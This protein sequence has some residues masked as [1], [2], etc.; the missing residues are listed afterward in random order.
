[1]GIG[2]WGAIS[3]RD[4]LDPA[5]SGPE[6]RGERRLADGGEST[7][8]VGAVEYTAD[9]RSN[10]A[11][12]AALEPHHSHFILVDTG[13]EGRAAWGNEIPLRF[14]IERKVAA[15]HHRAPCPPSSPT[16]S[17]AR[18][19]PTPTPTPTPTRKPR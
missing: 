13:R 1:V 4:E 5:A 19:R 17:P 16:P 15:R 6:L 3:N 12:G 14:A 7:S 11:E 9:R 2:P 8:V 10:S 18:P